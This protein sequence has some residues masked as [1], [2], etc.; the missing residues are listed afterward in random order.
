MQQRQKQPSKDVGFTFRDWGVVAIGDNLKTQTRRLM[1]PQPPRG[2]TVGNIS[3]EGQVLEWIL[4]D[5]HGDEVDAPCPQP[6]ANV[7][8]RIYVKE[9]YQEFCPMWS[10]QWC[11]HGDQEGMKRD[12]YIV[13]RVSDPDGA[14][15][16][17]GEVI[18]CKGWR[19]SRFMHKRCARYFR[20]LTSVRAQR[21]QEITEE[22]A[23]AE[24]C[25][26]MAGYTAGGAMGLASARYVYK[27]K[28]EEINGPGSWEQNA[29]VW[30]YGWAPGPP[31]PLPARTEWMR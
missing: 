20:L 21:I 11:G 3:A 25:T 16:W 1:Y 22:D 15:V 30:A 14:L 26:M 7:G 8:D 17:N 12:H 27:K 19:S 2:L 29:W 10:G 13:Y 18:H 5:R 28:W 23:V 9:T 4:C 24:G 31:K 6:R